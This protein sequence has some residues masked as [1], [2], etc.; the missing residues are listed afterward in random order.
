VSAADAQV[1]AHFHRF[2]RIVGVAVCAVLATLLGVAAP[3]Q[4]ADGQLTITGHGY[5]HGRGMGQ[6]GALGYAVDQGWSHSQILGHYYGGTT[7]A[8][9]AGN[10]TIAVELTRFTGADTIVTGTGLTLD[11]QAAGQAAML[12]RRTASDTVQVFRG[13]SC[14]GPWTSWKTVSSGAT[15]A[16]TASASNLNNLLKM[17]EAGTAKGYRGAISVVAAGGTQYTL[18]R[19]TADEYLRGVVPRES[20]ASWADAG[21]GRGLQALKAQAV[22]ARSYA[23]SSAARASGALTCDTTT[24]QVYG[25]AISW[26]GSTVTGLE[27]ARSDRAVSETSGQVMRFANGTI[28]RTEFSSSTGGWTAGGTFPAVQ[29]LGDATASNPNRTWTVTKSYSEVAAALGTGAIRSVV[30]SARNGLGADG[31]RATQV[32]VTTTSGSTKQVTGSAFRSALGL[33]SDWFTLSGVSAQESEAVVRALYRDILGREP[34]AQGLATWTAMVAQTGNAQQVARGI[35]NSTER[36]HTF[37]RAEYRAALKRAPE[38]AG[39]EHWTA[40]MQAGTNVPELQIY[41]Y[42]SDEA[43]LNL[44]R[45]N[46][47][48]WVDGV[49][50]GIL[51][52]S[53][54]AS[55]R[56]YWAGVAGRSD[57]PTVVRSIAMSDEA[58]LR[59]LDGYYA[60]ML[61]RKPDASGISTYL[62]QMR[63]K[64]D[65]LLP[66]EIGGSPEYWMRAQIR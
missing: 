47:G 61:Q 62:P 49:Y 56:S 10:P 37:I 8:T 64:R 66:I 53:A 21:G 22:A 1:R 57:R 65:F 13:A 15:V 35:V 9:N 44:G 51:G 14:A 55:E 30:V 5:G 26:S 3:A 46:L 40:Y 63:G 34:D 2:A 24:C 29:D 18:N 41:I 4:A 52:R 7:L 6:Y 33:K 28:A 42:A 23:L 11:G 31:G 58:G 59:R 48:A 17:C 27:D 36:L 20:P 19:V 54:S 43:L 39:L 38:A 45:G 25:G 12:L 50:Q 60:T 32:T 16:T